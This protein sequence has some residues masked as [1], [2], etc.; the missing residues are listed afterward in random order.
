MDEVKPL[1]DKLRELVREFGT[2]FDLPTIKPV[3]AAQSNGS[4]QAKPNNFQDSLD[5]LRICIKYQL[6]DLEATRRENDYLR[7]MLEDRNG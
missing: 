3:A 6:F 5:Y 2:T 1:E 7:K 4:E